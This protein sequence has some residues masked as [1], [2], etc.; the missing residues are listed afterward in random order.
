MDMVMFVIWEILILAFIISSVVSLYFT[1]LRLTLIFATVAWLLL[2]CMK[3]TKQVKLNS[4]TK[5]RMM[6]PLSM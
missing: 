4:K 3:V 1:H 6:L 5:R 2:L